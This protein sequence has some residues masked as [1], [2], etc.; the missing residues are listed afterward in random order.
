MIPA[1]RSPFLAQVL[2]CWNWK[3]ALMSATVRSL[4]YLSAM[5]RNG[6]KESLAVVAVEIVYVTLTAGLYAGWQQQALGLRRRWLGNLI[7]VCGVPGLSQALDW[8]AHRAVGA[9][10]PA[11]AT[12]AVCLFATLSALF[13]LYVMRRGAFLTG[14]AG[15][16]LTD[17]FRRMPRLVAGFAAAPVLTAAAWYHR[18][19]QHRNAAFQPAAGD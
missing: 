9:P 13:H 7:V 6:L 16:S 8:L 4:I 2:S 1:G 10:V 14:H 15:R 17:D 12:L 18:A 11:H 19:A 3:C 5:A